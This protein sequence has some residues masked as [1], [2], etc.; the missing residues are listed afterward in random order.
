[1]WQKSQ[2]STISLKIGHKICCLVV[3][4]TKIFTKN[5]RKIKR[6]NTL[7]GKAKKYE[8]LVGYW[9]VSISLLL[10]DYHIDLLRLKS[11][12][13]SKSSFIINMYCDTIVLI[14]QGSP[15]AG[16]GAKSE[17]QSIS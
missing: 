17:P 10:N 15:T 16:P 12:I 6:K 2:A 8:I 7:S 13:S 1:M 14:E 11:D 9:I 3:P 5:K 4:I